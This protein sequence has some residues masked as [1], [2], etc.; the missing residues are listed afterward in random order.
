MMGF[1]VLKNR[2]YEAMAVTMILVFSIIFAVINT[3]E[4]YD[5]SKI[6]DDLS[7]DRVYTDASF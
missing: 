2:P 4:V 6:D 7:E 3:E 5:L 1:F